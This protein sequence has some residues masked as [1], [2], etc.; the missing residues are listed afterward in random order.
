MQN[1]EIKTP[2]GLVGWLT[3]D[4]IELIQTDLQTEETNLPEFTSNLEENTK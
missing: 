1:F 2:N 3:N 4:E